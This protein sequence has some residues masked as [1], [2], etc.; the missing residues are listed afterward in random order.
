MRKF[1][2]DGSDHQ[3]HEDLA[4]AIHDYLIWRNQHRGQARRSLSPNYRSKA[5]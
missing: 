4:D 1:V 2:I 5:A 3:S